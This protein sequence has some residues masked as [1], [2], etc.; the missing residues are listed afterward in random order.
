METKREQT[1]MKCLVNNTTANRAKSRILIGI[2]LTLIF[3]SVYSLSTIYEFPVLKAGFLF[4]TL[5]KTVP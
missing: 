3:L 5:L 4:K 1:P 2:I